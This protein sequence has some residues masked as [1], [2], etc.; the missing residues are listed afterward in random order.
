VLAWQGADRSPVYD[1]PDWGFRAN[2]AINF[3]AMLLLRDFSV[4]RPA[5]GRLCGFRWRWA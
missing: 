3:I 5:C 2:L 4:P 1:P